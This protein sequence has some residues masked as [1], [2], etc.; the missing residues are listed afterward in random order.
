[1]CIICLSQACDLDSFFM[2]AEVKYCDLGILP[3]SKMAAR[4]LRFKKNIPTNE[5]V[6]M[7]GG[8]TSRG[9]L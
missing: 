9:K 7:I 5:V 6:S 8:S 4:D 3:A 1:M 2:F